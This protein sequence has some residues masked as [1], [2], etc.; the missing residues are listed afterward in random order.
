MKRRTPF[1]AIE[2]MGGRNPRHV[3]AGGVTN[4]DIEAGQDVERRR[5]ER[6]L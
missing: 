6:V 3:R 1:G 2:A 5:P 4:A